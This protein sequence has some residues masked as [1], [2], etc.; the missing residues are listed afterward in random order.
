MRPRLC[1]LYGSWARK[2]EHS[3]ERPWRRSGHSGARQRRGCHGGTVTPLTPVIRAIIST[4][5]ARGHV[6]LY[7]LFAFL[8][9]FVVALRSEP[10]EVS[11]GWQIEIECPWNAEHS[12][13]ARRDTVLASLPGLGNGFKCFHSHCSQRHWREFHD[14]S[15][16]SNPRLAPYYASCQS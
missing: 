16:R 1:K 9:Y 4:E 2:G 7:S 15:K 5:G 13:E 6:K 11:G 3:E 8:N 14:D 10:R 12:D